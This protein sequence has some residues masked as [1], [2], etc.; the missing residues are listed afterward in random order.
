MGLDGIQ[1]RLRGICLI[2]LLG[3][4]LNTAALAAAS[5]NLICVVVLAALQFAVGETP[6]RAKDSSSPKPDTV[7]FT[8][9][10]VLVYL[11]HHD[12]LQRQRGVHG[13]ESV[14]DVVQ[15]TVLTFAEGAH[16]ARDS[17]LRDFLR[18]QRDLVLQG[19]KWQTASAS[20]NGRCIQQH[21]SVFWNST[22]TELTSLLTFRDNLASFLSQTSSVQAH[23]A[24]T[25]LLSAVVRAIGYSNRCRSTIRRQL[26]SALLEF[27][28]ANVSWRPTGRFHVLLGC[29]E[30]AFWEGLRQH[31]WN[32]VL[33]NGD[34]RHYALSE[35]LT[36]Q[37]V[38]GAPLC[39][40]LTLRQRMRVA[41][42]LVDIPWVHPGVA[43][44]AEYHLAQALDH[45]EL[46]GEK[47]RAAEA[48]Q[49]ATRSAAPIV[50]WQSVHEAGVMCNAFPFLFASTWWQFHDDISGIVK[51][52][53]SHSKMLAAEARVLSDALP[54][55]H[56]Y[57]TINRDDIDGTPAWSSLDVN[58][59]R[60]TSPKTYNF[61]KRN[62]ML[63]ESER[64]V[65]GIKWKAMWSVLEPGAQ[66]NAHSGHRA[67][68]N[69]Q[70]CV[71]GCA[72]SMLSIGGF[73]VPY[74]FGKALAWQD[75]FRHSVVN[76]GREPRWNFHVTR[77]HPDV[78]RVW[79]DRKT[80]GWHGVQRLLETL[81]RKRQVARD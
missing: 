2:Y 21:S 73:E 54:R 45:L 6:L 68:I 63:L 36:V 52:L 14:F 17:H 9:D 15:S 32:R 24:G 26:H 13:C 81:G 75:S 10:G 72:G 25:H 57:V 20:S 61:V 66:L 49:L 28:D 59:T 27:S 34:L 39:A 62:R 79:G 16:N 64:H 4:C 50:H 53:E 67:R 8:L 48:F 5:S 47:G 80:L 51:L 69:I 71:L 7:V 23:E 33:N 29:M 35:G 70:V 18:S 22:S 56:A 76:R 19:T 3:A 41:N 11:A 58:A 46:A 30:H 43:D 44:C 77:A 40:Q 65:P 78:L 38:L 55:Q 1:E 12:D 42:D 60:H 74:L 31:L 37:F